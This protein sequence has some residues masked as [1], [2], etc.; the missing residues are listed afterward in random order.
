MDD[1]ETMIIFVISI[2]RAFINHIN[3]TILNY[4][5]WCNKLIMTILFKHHKHP[6]SNNTC[7]CSRFIIL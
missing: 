2:K 1:T 7:S 4:H 3:D 6:R 5:S